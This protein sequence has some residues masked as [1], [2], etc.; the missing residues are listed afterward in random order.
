MSHK[1]K[2]PLLVHCNVPANQ[3]L[4]DRHGNS[5]KGKQLRKV[6]DLLACGIYAYRLDAID[7]CQTAGM[8]VGSAN[9]AV[10]ALHPSRSRTILCSI[11][12]PGALRKS[13]QQCGRAV[14]K[15]QRWKGAGSTVS[16]FLIRDVTS[17]ASP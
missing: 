13:L 4:N 9:R 17:H 3:A 6:S 14:L 2:T 7:K 11:S 8:C 12:R 15:F 16:Y 5:L 1:H 10:E